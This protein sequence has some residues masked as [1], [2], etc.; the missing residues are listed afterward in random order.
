MSRAKALKYYIIIRLLLAPLMLWTITTLVFLLLRATP[1][2]PVDAVLGNRAPDI[3][4][5]D[6]RKQLG[7][8]DPLWL[9]YIRY[10]GSLLRL[11]LGTSI[12]SQGQKVWEIIQQHFPATVELSVC[13]MA[14]AFLVGIGV[15]TLAA[16]RSGTVWDVGGRLFGIITYSIPL[17]WMGMVVQLIF[18]VQLGWFPIGT[19]YPISLATPEGFTGLYTIDSLF[20]GNLVQF[21]TAIYYLA[22]PSIT[23]GLL[24]SG[25]FERIV[26][27]NL[28]QT[29]KADYVEAARARGIHER[30]I[31][32]AH[33]LK[34][35][36]I[37]VI[38]VLGLTLAALLGG[39]VLTEV[40]FSWPGLGNRLYEAISGRDYPTVQGIM[41]FFAT[42]VV[43]ASIAIDIVNALIDPRIRY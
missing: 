37:P 2:D 42:I 26:R 24:L 12:T 27:V 19:R 31:V 39:A 16:S 30:R 21:F 9:Q 41:V 35:A 23:L 3:V 10:L 38:T 6:Y 5:E 1:G 4:K 18:S 15:G 25:I 29:L 40:T 8:A 36:M 34:N 28:K 20:S 14:I 32:F 22:L 33:A 11:D 7:L 43:I 17:F 13:G